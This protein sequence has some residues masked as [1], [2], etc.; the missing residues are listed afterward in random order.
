[1]N[2]LYFLSQQF[3]LKSAILGCC[4]F[5]F[6]FIS[7]QDPHFT[8]YN[9]ANQQFNPAMTGQFEQTVRATL[10]HRSQW[11]TVGTGYKTNGVDAQYKLL[12]YVSD[13]YAGFGL[14]VLQDEMGKAGMKTF[15]VMGTAAYHLVAN[16]KNLLSSGVTL[17]Y[18]QR[19]LDTRGLTWDAQFNGISYDPSL[20]DKERVLT[21]RRSTIDIGVGVNWKH[22]GKKRYALGYALRHA[23]QQVTQVARGND[24]IRFR[25]TFTAQWISKFK[26]FDLRY[27]AMVQRQAGAQEIV[28]GLTG[29]YRLGSD[30]RYTNVKTSN[31]IMAG[32]FYRYNDAIH[33][34][35]G[36]EIY[37]VAAITFGYDFRSPKMPGITTGVGGPEFSISYLGSYGRKRM[38]VY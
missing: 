31:S 13:S 7:A 15:A 30:S 37:H 12:S 28:F 27:D 1:M 35:I 4:L 18:Y 8:N 22:K 10:L 9:I 34:Y 19:N 3:I 23:S 32:V 33:P 25:Q 5:S 20:D 11:R 2:S 6:L 14:F 17:G 16:Q 24:R 38:K 26:Y 36:A 21:D 29:F